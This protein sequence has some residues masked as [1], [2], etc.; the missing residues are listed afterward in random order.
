[1]L[2]NSVSPGRLP[3]RLIVKVTVPVFSLIV[4]EAGEIE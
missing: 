2:T 1:V 4:V 3:E